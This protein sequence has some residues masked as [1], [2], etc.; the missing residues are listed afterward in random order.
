MLD[1]PMGSEYIPTFKYYLFL[2]STL[3]SSR[4]EV[5]SKKVVFKN[6]IKFTGKHLCQSLFFNKVAFLRPEKDNNSQLA[7]FFFSVS[8]VFVSCHENYT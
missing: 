7:V 4:L 1:V 6:F 5:F 2:L 3:R 8:Q